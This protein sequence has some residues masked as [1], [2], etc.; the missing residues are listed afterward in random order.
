MLYRPACVQQGIATS[1]RKVVRDKLLTVIHKHCGTL[2]LPA[3]TLRGRCLLLSISKM[4]TCTA[5]S[6]GPFGACQ[7]WQT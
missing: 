4:I 3:S 6:F 7:G 2:A 5:D 1:S